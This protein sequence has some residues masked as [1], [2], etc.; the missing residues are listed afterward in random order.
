MVAGLVERVPPRGLPVARVHAS[1]YATY[2]LAALV[3]AWLQPRWPTCAAAL[4]WLV[5]LGV[6]ACGARRVRRAGEAQSA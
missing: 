4:P 3:T 5:W 2:G 6:V 1:V